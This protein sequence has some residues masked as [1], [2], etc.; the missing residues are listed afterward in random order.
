MHEMAILFGVSRQTLYNW[1]KGNPTNSIIEGRATE[2]LRAIENATVTGYLPL[3]IVVDKPR[4]MAKIK[5][6]LA[7][8]FKK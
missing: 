2:M 4:R 3:K 7:Q 5:M 1:Q 6:A 8:S